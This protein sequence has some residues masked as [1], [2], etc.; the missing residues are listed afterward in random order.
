MKG[1]L[2]KL[3]LVSESSE[4]GK[5]VQVWGGAEMEQLETIVKSGAG[6]EEGG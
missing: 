5:V 1:A 2:G 6:G 3:R 4:R